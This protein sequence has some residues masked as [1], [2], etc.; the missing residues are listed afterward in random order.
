MSCNKKLIVF[1]FLILIKCA[2]SQN[3][4]SL[5]RSLKQAKHDSTKLRLQF[6]I[7]SV[8]NNKRISHW[9]SLLKE[10]EKLKDIKTEAK[11]LHYIGNTILFKS[12]K[13]FK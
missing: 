5:K 9:D 3:V 7:S 2:F 11:I 12:G 8:A 6:T 10:S 1:F 4:D 13:I